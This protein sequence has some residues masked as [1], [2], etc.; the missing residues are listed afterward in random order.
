MRGH[1]EIILLH[2]MTFFKCVVFHCWV[3]LRPLKDVEYIE[4][5]IILGHYINIRVIST[6]GTI[7]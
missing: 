5:R 4:I 6:I 1:D 3:F 2:P 7:M